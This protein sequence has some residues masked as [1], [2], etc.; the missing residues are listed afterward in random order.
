VLKAPGAIK[1]TKLGT[2]TVKKQ[3]LGVSDIKNKGDGKAADKTAG[4]TAGVLK[5]PGLLDMGGGGFAAGSPA[6]M[7]SAMPA[8]G[9]AHTTRLR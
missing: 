7:G 3:N 8:G 2:A 5:S 9:G 6:P 1:T 4:K